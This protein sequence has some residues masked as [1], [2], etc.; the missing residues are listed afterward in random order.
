ME[1]NTRSSHERCDDVLLQPNVDV[2]LQLN[3]VLLQLTVDV[4]LQLNV[5]LLLQ[6]NVEALHATSTQ[7]GR[8]FLLLTN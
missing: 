3:D 1:N 2:L 5:D 8:P 7:L 6:L 4:L